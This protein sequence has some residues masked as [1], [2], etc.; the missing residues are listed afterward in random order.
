MMECSYKGELV[1]TLKVDPATGDLVPTGESVQCEGTATTS[2]PG[3][4]VDGT[5]LPLCPTCN[6]RFGKVLSTVR[7]IN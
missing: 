1:E 2:I 5:D 7:A 6:L 4:F 3:Y